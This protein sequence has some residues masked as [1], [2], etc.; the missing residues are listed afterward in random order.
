MSRFRRPGQLAL[1]LL[2]LPLAW[3]AGCSRPVGLS[4][5]EDAT[6]PDQHQVPFQEGNSV[7]NGTPASSVPD[8]GLKP[9]TDLPFR[10]PQNLPAGTL[11]T[12][13]LKSSV[14]ADNPKG[15]DTFE[16]VV[17][18]PVTIEGNTLVPRGASVVG[19]VESASGASARGSASAGI[20]EVK[21]NGYVRLTLESIDI[22]GTGKDQPLQTSSLFARGRPAARNGVL[23]LITLEKGR[24]LTFR[25][26]EPAYVALQQSVT[27][28]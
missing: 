28:H 12:V 26:T 4:G 23:G 11:L 2:L 1:W 13:R 6:A 8:K 15:R 25:L 21:R 9:G 16:A 17:D 20:P 14:S 22:A 18:E 3:E 19:R 7:A 24:R 5:P 10:D 27:D